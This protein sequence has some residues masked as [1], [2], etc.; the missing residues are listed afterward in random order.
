ML[1]ARL[2]SWMEAQ[3]GRAKKRKQ[4]PRSPPAPLDTAPPPHLSSPESAYS[5]GYSTDGTSPGAP[6][7]LVAPPPPPAPPTTHLYHEP[8]KRRSSVTVRRLPD[9]PAACATPSPRP[10]CRIKT[11]PWLGGTSPSRRRAPQ[12]P[13]PPPLLHHAPYSL[14][15]SSARFGTRSPLKSPLRSPY[16]RGGAS[17]DEECRGMRTR[18]RETAILSDNDVDSDGDTGL[19]G[20]DED[21]PD[22]DTASPSR[23]RA[24]RRRPPRRPPRSAGATPPRARRRAH[25]PSAPPARRDPLLEADREA[26]RKYREL[27]R[28]AEKLLVSVSRAPLEPPHNPRIRELRATEV[29]APRRSPERT[30]ITNFMR[31]NSPEPPRRV[32]PV[33]RRSPLARQPAPAERPQ[34][35]PPK[36]KAY[37]REEVLQTLEGLRKSLQQ[38]SALLAVQR[39][40]LDSL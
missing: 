6:P 29:E 17:S 34:S 36:R 15:A 21:E 33:A 14:D 11:N 16:H 31:A 3:L 22:D 26:E 9:I 30:H 13:P 35:E 10:R 27:I 4:K 24:R 28:E 18:G 39:T 19:D 38:Q 20:G 7:P 2:K 32:S 23:R 8:A 40:R 5:T 25:A 1:G 12:P 37:A